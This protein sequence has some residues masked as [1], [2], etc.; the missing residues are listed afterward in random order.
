MVEK[1]Q[2][3]ENAKKQRNLWTINPVT[4]VPKNPKAYDRA[5]DRKDKRLYEVE[6]ETIN[7]SDETP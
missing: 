2:K 7:E 3:K 5:R 4:R 6:E 1:N